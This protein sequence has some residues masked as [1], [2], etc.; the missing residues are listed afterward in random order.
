MLEE[1]NSGKVGGPP[2]ATVIRGSQEWFAGGGGGAEHYSPGT[3]GVGDDGT[4]A[5]GNPSNRFGTVAATSGYTFGSGGGGG[6][7]G[8]NGGQT[9]FA[10]GSGN[11]GIVILRVLAELESPSVSQADGSGG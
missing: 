8:G 5:G 10:G 1:P 11:Q 4:L 6:N 7:Y 2:E 3:G 9:N